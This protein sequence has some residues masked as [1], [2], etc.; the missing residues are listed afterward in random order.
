MAA[1]NHAGQFA[2]AEGDHDAAALAHA[3]PQR[4]RQRVSERLIERNGQA[5]VA[6]EAR[7]GGH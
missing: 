3:M 4:L 1:Q 7:S 5:D 6:I 2:R